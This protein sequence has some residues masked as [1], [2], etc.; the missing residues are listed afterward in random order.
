MAV[1]VHKDSTQWLGG[2]SAAKIHRAEAIEIRTIDR[3]LIG[4]L[5]ARLDRRMSFA[6]SISDG[7]LFV[8]LA[9][10]TLTGAVTRVNL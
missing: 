2:L 1:Y 7:E 9:D 10:A 8:S 3:A 4:A 6:L 5:C